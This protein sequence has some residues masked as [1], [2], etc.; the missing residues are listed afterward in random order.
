MRIPQPRVVLLLSACFILQGQTCRPQQPRTNFEFRTPTGELDPPWTSSS[1]T[2][3]GLDVFATL[4]DYEAAVIPVLTDTLLATPEVTSVLSLAYSFPYPRF[5]ISGEQTT[6]VG[7]LAGVAEA[8]LSVT[9]RHPDS[10]IRFLCGSNAQVDARITDLSAQTRYDFFTGDS[11]DIDIGYSS[12]DADF[13]CSTPII[14]DLVELVNDIFGIVDVAEE[15]VLALEDL[16]G[17]AEESI[18]GRYANLFALEDALLNAQENGP[19]EIREATDDVMRLLGGATTAAAAFIAEEITQELIDRLA[20]QTQEETDLLRA[21]IGDLEEEIAGAIPGLTGLTL[22]QLNALDLSD[23]LTP[24]LPAIRTYLLNQ[25]D[26]FYVDAVAAVNNI[27]VLASDALEQFVGAD[28]NRLFGGVNV[29]I[30]LNRDLK[31]VVVDA[32]HTA[33]ETFIGRGHIVIPCLLTYEIEETENVVSYTFFAEQNNHLYTG[34]ERTNIFVGRLR[35]ASVTNY[36]GL[37]SYTKFAEEELEDWDGTGNPWS[38]CPFP[39]SLVDTGTGGTGGGGTGGTAGT[40]GTG[41]S[42]GTAGTGGTGG[43]GGT[44]ATAGSGG[45][46]GNGGFGNICGMEFCL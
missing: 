24:L 22:P 41:G 46:G 21:R 8:S 27:E 10:L 20:L 7:T 15:I 19:A 43:S 40:G 30:R 23:Y 12:V 1:V 16:E 42:G 34:P 26:A 39:S 31:R 32:Y 4:A 5:V 45:N 37:H 2:V 25:L 11:L 36:F 9:Y 44:G 33:P 18:N 29:R 17:F 14:G 3:P 35:A 28:W 6:I 13:D 38:Q